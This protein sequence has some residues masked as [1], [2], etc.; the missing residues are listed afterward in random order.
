MTIEEINNASEEVY[1]D[2]QWK[3]LIDFFWDRYNKRYF[4][5]IEVLQKHEDFEIRNNCGFLIATIDCI[6]IETLV[7]IMMNVVTPFRG[8]LYTPLAAMCGSECYY[9]QAKY[10]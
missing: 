8:K 1:Q 10:N 6:L 4:D 9:S 2:E 5:Q 3:P 7:Y